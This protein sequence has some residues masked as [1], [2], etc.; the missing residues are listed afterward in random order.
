MDSIKQYVITITAAAILCMLV[1]AIFPAKNAYG[2]IL[3]LFCGVVFTIILV[4]PV[5]NFCFADYNWF[6][7]SIFTEA[8]IATEEGVAAFNGLLSDSIK[9]KTTAYIL[10]KA[11]EYDMDLNIQVELEDSSPPV[12]EN[13]IISGNSTP[14]QREQF[15]LELSNELGLP[16]ERILWQWNP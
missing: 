9:D 12:P 8:N 11:N 10:D 5:N 4:S 15:R 3:K 14:L 16:K 7:E 13:I 2:G 1:N 6:W